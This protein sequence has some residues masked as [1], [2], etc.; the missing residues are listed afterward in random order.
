MINAHIRNAHIRNALFASAAALIVSAC[1]ADDIAS[2]GEGNIVVIGTPAPSPTP[3]PTPT[4]VSGPAASC[5]TGFTNAGVVGQSRACEL[6]NQINGTLSLDRVAGVA[7]VMNG[8]VDVGVDVGGDGAAAGGQVGTLNIAAGVTVYAANANTFLIVNR[9]SAL[10]ATGTPTAPI[11]FTSRQNILGTATD[12]DRNQWGGILLLG[13]APISDCI[14][15]A[16]GGAADCQQQAEGA[17]PQD[18]YGGNVP[19]DDSGT[20]QYVQIRYTGNAS[21][22]NRELQGLTLAGVGSNTTVSFVQSHNSGDDGIEIF[23]GT[24]NLDHILITGADDDGF[25]TDSGYTGAT[26]FMINVQAPGFGDAGWEVD[27]DDIAFNSIPR[28]DVKLANFTFIHRL[29][30]DKAIHLRGGPDAKI[31]NG[32]VVGPGFCLDVDQA[33]TVQAANAALDEDGP[34]VFRSVVF[35]CANGAFDSDSD[36]FEATAFNAPG[37]TNNNSNFTS[38]LTMLFINGANET[39]VTAVA[40]LTSFSSSFTQVDYIGAVRDANDVWYRSWSCN[41]SY[42]DFGAPANCVSVPAT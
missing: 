26:Q 13:R 20:I 1:G 3:A 6:P 18:F 24:V 5:P 21:T 16:V 30:S 34:P 15:G 7:Y 19:A 8:R 31:L 27:S 14:L 36:T 25:D 11:I 29:A 23:G 41:A 37:N 35:S 2:P 4:P 42:V 38:T 10:N 17:G 22:P 12:D 28:Q 39:A 32:V 33:E 40:N 9:G